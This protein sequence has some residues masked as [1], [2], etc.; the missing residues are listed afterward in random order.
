[1][2][3]QIIVERLNDMQSKLDALKRHQAQTAAK[4]DALL[5]ACAGSGP[6]GAS[7]RAYQQVPLSFRSSTSDF[8]S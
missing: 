1:M 4:L 6:S 8:V 2:D 7:F 3:Q 5:P